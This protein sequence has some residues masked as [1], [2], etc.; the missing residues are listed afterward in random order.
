[1]TTKEKSLCILV[2]GVLALLV[3]VHQLGSVNSLDLGAILEVALFLC[4]CYVGIR[5]INF[6]IKHLSENIIKP[7][8][9]AVKSF[10]YATNQRFQ[11][12]PPIIKIAKLRGQRLLVWLAL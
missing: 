10:V 9:T 7:T 6:V 3:Y 4:F 12:D 2:L 5:T 1:M 8:G 11:L